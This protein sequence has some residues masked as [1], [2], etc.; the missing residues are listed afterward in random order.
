MAFLTDFF[1]LNRLNYIRTFNNQ[2]LTTKTFLHRYKTHLAGFVAL[3]PFSAMF[4]S[5]EAPK[6]V[7]LLKTERV[8]YFIHGISNE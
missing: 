6:C 2:L 5:S 7:L 1:L 3:S 8:C 4:C